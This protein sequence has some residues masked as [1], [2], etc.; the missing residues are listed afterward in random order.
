MQ[1]LILFY[2][3]ILMVG[4]GKKSP[5]NIYD[6]EGYKNLTKKEITV[7]ESIWATTCFRC[8]MYGSM[9]AASVRDKTHIEQ[10]AAKGF[11]QLYTSVLNGMEGTEGVMPAKGTCFTCS[12]DEIKNSVYYIFHLAKKF[13]DAELSEKEI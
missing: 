3:F 11:D 6:S 9:G 5:V 12:E 13:Q 4:C 8:H 1:R 7:G 2:I 10:L